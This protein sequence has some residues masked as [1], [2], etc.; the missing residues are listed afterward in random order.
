[1]SGETPDRTGLMCQL[2]LGHVYKN[3]DIG[4]VD[5]WFTSEGQA[6]GLIQLAERYHF[7][8]ILLSKSGIDPDLRNQVKSVKKYKDG[9]TITWIDG[10]QTYVPPNSYPVSISVTNTEFMK[11]IDELDPEE[12]QA[13]APDM[14]IHKYYFDILDYVITRKGG[15]LSI[16]GEVGSVFERFLRQLG[17]FDSGLIALVEDPDKCMKCMKA[18]NRQVIT[19]ALAQ[20]G[21]PID[22]M[23]ISSPFAGAGFISP[24]YYKKF[25]LP[26]EQELISEVHSKYNIPCYLHTCGA[27]GDRLDMMLESGIDGIECLDPPPLGTVDLTQAVEQIGQSVWIKGNLD[28]VNEMLSNSPARVKKIALDRIKIGR[29]AKGY[30][31]STA[32]SLAPDVP[33]E[34][35]RALYDA[36]MEAE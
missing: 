6:E 3:T 22:A 15:S 12:Y 28:S 36:V 19:E 5:F 16:H 10:K 35:V 8:G 14:N 30:I 24:D 7:D 17:S 33:P 29:K 4:P 23:K 31:L 13:Q 34:S 2:S 25:V 9:H 27:I 11:N 1:M 18:M 32:C 20:C 21:R 26:F